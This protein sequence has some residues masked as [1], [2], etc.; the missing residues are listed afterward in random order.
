MS[1][2]SGP[3]ES[4]TLAGRR[5]A[6]DA[7][8]DAKIIIGGY[9]N[10]V[11]PNGDKSFRILKS[12]EASGVESMPLQYDNDRGDREFLQGLRDGLE[13]FDFSCTE[14]DGTIYSGSMQIT[15]DLKFST[16]EGTVDVSVAGKIE[17]QG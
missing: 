10:D 4:A 14:V 5:F 1:Q 2:S 13:P 15:D 7:E 11:K 9:K 8:A 12:L 6:I 17:K 16:K 3:L